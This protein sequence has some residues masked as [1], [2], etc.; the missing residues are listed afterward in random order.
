MAWRVHLSDR[1]IKRLDMLSGKPSL[2]AAWTATNR[3]SFLDL[4]NGSP[5]G[6]MTIEPVKDADRRGES[7]QTFVQSLTTPNN[8]Y[9]PTARA[10]QAAIFLSADGSTRLYYTG[11]T[12]LYLEIDGKEAKI[13]T[14][15][16][17][18]FIAIGMDRASG[19]LAALDADARLHLYHKHVRV[20]VFDT[21]LEIDEEFRPVLII[22]ADGKALFVSDGQRITAFDANGKIRQHLPLH[23]TLGAINSSP[24]GRRFVTS[25]LDANV[26]RIYDGNLKPT[27]Q[28]YAMDLLTE[29]KRAQLLASASTISAAVGP[30]A[31]NNK[32]VLA[33]AIAGT[34]CVTSLSKLKAFPKT[35]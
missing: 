30:L 20:G 19:L 22:S 29:A 21:Q 24:N 11:G 3:V 9:L 23:Y 33:F 5:R 10:P 35:R 26:I 18:R 25:D 27:H 12:D 14:D 8:L 31:I 15:A 28:R 4:Q 17:P 1:N 32:G 13:E 34:L 7:W 16:K 2:L 6:D